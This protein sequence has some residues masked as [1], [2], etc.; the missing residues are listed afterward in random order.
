MLK[1]ALIC[2]IILIIMVGAAE[3]TIKLKIAAVNP[4]TTS[5]KVCPV[6]YYLPKGVEPGAIID[7]GEMSLGYDF[8]KQSYYVHQTI[9][10]E[11]SEKRIL[12]I[13][14]EDIWIVPENEIEFFKSHTGGLVNRLAG[15]RHADVGIE[16]SNMI[17]KELNSIAQTQ[18]NPILTAREKMNIYYENVGYL[19]KIKENIGK[20]EN[21]VID[22]GGI[23]EERVE[24]PDT[25]AVAIPED[26]GIGPWETIELKVGVSNPSETRAQTANVQYPLPEEV[27]PS[28][29][30]DSG[31]LELGYDFDN[32]CYYGFKKDVPL[33]PSERKIFVIRIKDIWRVP[34]VEI[35]A[36]R[37]HTNN[38]IL[39]LNG[40]EYFTQGEAIANKV[41]FNLEEIVTSQNLVVPPPEHI[42]F[43]RDNLKTFK[44]VKKYIAHLE[45]L[46]SK[47][48]AMPGITI[49]KAEV[50]I[51]GGPKVKK[52]RG[53]EGIAFIAK[54]IFRG[55]APTPATT[56]KIIFVII[57]FIGVV[58]L[59]FYLLW[60]SQVRRERRRAAERKT[61]I[62]K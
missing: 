6:K 48:G 19:R 26:R 59:A 9:T 12:E 45:K 44:S 54:T 41:Y 7:T 18:G 25:L 17:T 14:L 49:T 55:K 43:Y 46:V 5:Q 60:Q 36:L 42:A 51:G 30:L 2:F 16:L 15:T 58:S 47:A 22:V 40:T 31:E 4:S 10:L 32:E 57:G 34:E 1:K 37:A 52:P 3:A 29:V 20:L 21:L 38:L 35:G 27:V 61:K 8:E 28:D 53:Y 24:V 62:Q 50:E 33:E 39:L 23:I 11:P 13:E 56:W